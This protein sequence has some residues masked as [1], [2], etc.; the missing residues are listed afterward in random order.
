[1]KSVYIRFVFYAMLG[2]TL[3]T[4]CRRPSSDSSDLLGNWSTS[5]D[6]KGDTRSEAAVFVIDNI[7]YVLTGTNASGSYNDMY[8]FD[9]NNG[10]WT[11]KEFL[12]GRA[13]NGAVAFSIN[14]KGYIATGYSGDADM[15]DC[16]EYNPATKSWTPK[17]DFP[18]EA[19][20]D[21]VAFVYN[22][23]AYV[24]SGWDS[25]KAF[26]D[27]WEFDPA[28]APGSQWQEKASMPHKTLAAVAF[29]LNNKGYVMAGNNNGEIQKELYEFDVDHNVWTTK[30]KL[31][32]YSNESYDDKYTTIARDNA[33]AFVLGNYAYVSTGE[34]GSFVS[35]TWQ[36]DA[37]NDTWTEFTG[38]EAKA[39]EGA[40]AFAINNRAFV[41]TGKNGNLYMD[42]MFEFNPFTEK[43][44]GD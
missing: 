26:N 31:Y 28:A 37:V 8:A 4:A 9:V 3:L 35:S 13:R 30:R 40:V 41:L 14:G 5:V 43:V 12:P 20:H 7:A 23:K 25:K 39:R 17:D 38:F 1:M 16:W 22:G 11:K 18:A 42:N 10:N 21:A 24:C 19:R 29:V 32:N 27:C 15:V 36:Y 2:S 34:N 44:D 33:V 6:F